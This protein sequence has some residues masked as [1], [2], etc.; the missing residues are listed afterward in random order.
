MLPGSLEKLPESQVAACLESGLF[1]HKGMVW[2]FF[3]LTS[4]HCCYFS[5]AGGQCPWYTV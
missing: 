2:D 4:I 3:H 5:Q 1:S